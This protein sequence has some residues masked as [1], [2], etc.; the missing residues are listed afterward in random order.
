MGFL[1][2]FGLSV[3]LAEPKELNQSCSPGFYFA[4]SGAA[5]V[6]VRLVADFTEYPHH[7]VPHTIQQA[8]EIVTLDGQGRWAKNGGWEELVSHKK[9]LAR[10]LYFFVVSGMRVFVI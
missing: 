3:N 8:A 2:C 6:A 7:Y 4:L 9:A 5:Q 1:E 10:I